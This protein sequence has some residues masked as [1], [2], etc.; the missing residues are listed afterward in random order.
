MFVATKHD[1]EYLRQ[2]L[3]I[4]G[5]DSSFVY[6]SLDQTGYN[7]AN[8]L[9]LLLLLL[10]ILL[11]RKISVGKF[12]HKKT[13]VMIVTDVAVSLS[14]SLPPSLPLFLP[15]QYSFLSFRLVV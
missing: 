11:A 7:Y 5:I 4:A 1:V 14:P 3:L 10:L 13:H 6:S 2:L 15:H 9:L 8:N 12:F